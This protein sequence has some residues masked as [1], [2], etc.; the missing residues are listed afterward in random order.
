MSL[1]AGKW[2]KAI[3][4]AIDASPEGVP[5]DFLR[6]NSLSGKNAFMRAVY[7]L[8][9]K[10]R[11]IIVF[12]DDDKKLLRKPPVL[13][14]PI[15]VES[16][17]VELEVEPDDEPDDEPDVADA[18]DPGKEIERQVEASVQAAQTTPARQ[19]KKGE[20]PGKRFEDTEL[21]KE[22]HGHG[23]ATKE[24]DT[25]WI[26]AINQGRVKSFAQLKKQRERAKGKLDKADRENAAHTKG[27]P[28]HKDDRAELDQGIEQPDE[29]PVH[30]YA[31]DDGS[32]VEASDESLDSKQEKKGL[33]TLEGAGAVTDS[34]PWTKRRRSS[35]YFNN[36]AK[37]E[38][39][40]RAAP[41]RPRESKAQQVERLWAELT[42]LEK[43]R[44][45][46][47]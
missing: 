16:F 1:G 4:A 18:D 42:K 10:G 14:C 25:D 32:A 11:L 22:I 36:P 34:S 37:G 21:L 44:A 9:R 5:M 26:D 17:P 43:K 45:R 12:N 39:H 3:L 28:A 2:E 19:P 35:G 33:G 47:R 23:F 13:E 30:A 38:Y 24:F 27:D 40:T 8:E 6:L 31:H 15:I 46:D 29:K 41:P 20:W 7:G